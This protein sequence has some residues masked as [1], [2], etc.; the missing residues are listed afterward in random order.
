MQTDL[1]QVDKIARLSHL[2]QGVSVR[3]GD[4]EAIESRFYWADPNLF[5]VLPLPGLCR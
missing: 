1:P 3:H 4:V 5:E 2:F